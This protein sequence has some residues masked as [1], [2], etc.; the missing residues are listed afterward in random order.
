MHLEPTLIV[1][2]SGWPI[3]G[4]IKVTGSREHKLFL[5]LIAVDGSGERGDRIREGFDGS[6]MSLL[7]D[8]FL[9]MQ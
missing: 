1:A 8:E 6:R 9:L 7:E 4:D 3:Q 2:G 5:V